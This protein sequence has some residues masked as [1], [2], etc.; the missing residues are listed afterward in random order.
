[1]ELCVISRAEFIRA[2]R[3]NPHLHLDICLRINSWSGWKWLEQL[4]SEAASIMSQSTFGMDVRCNE[5]NVA[6]QRRGSGSPIKRN[7]KAGYSLGRHNKAE[8]RRSTSATLDISQLM[9]GNSNMNTASVGF[10]FDEESLVEL[11]REFD[12]M[13]EEKNEEVELT[14]E[15][16]EE[17][18][19]N[20][21]FE[22]TKTG[23]M[24]RQISD[25][26]PY[27]TAK[28]ETKD[29]KNLKRTDSKIA[30]KIKRAMELKGNDRRYKP[31]WQRQWEC[32]CALLMMYVE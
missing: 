22:N 14:E 6:D 21:L 13:Y 24:L 16:E 29:M 27:F 26:V 1:M 30:L 3:D 5:I 32:L 11:K 18:E 9:G 4:N 2:F 25:R 31:F 19:E 10:S 12:E 20:W 8:R 15:E 7:I 28:E 23:R 17:D